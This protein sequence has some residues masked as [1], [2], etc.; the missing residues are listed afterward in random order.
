MKF[1][2]GQGINKTPEMT[3]TEVTEQ[4]PTTSKKNTAA[5][6]DHKHSLIKSQ[7]SE[8]LKFNK[9]QVQMSAAKMNNVIIEESSEDCSFCESQFGDLDES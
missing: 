1:G 2:F 3:Y 5:L 6:E 7:V 8:K 4:M 9:H